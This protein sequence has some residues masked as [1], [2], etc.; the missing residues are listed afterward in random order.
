MP[1]TIPDYTDS[2]VKIQNI[3]HKNLLLDL[4]LEPG[5]PDSHS[6]TEPENHFYL[7]EKVEYG[8]GECS[9]FQKGINHVKYKEMDLE[10][11]KYVCVYII[12]IVYKIYKEIDFGISF[13]Y[14]M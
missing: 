5:A 9:P 6:E 14:L 2:G 1:G 11:L 3:S 10:L 8:A 13:N 7:A 12:Y 4:G